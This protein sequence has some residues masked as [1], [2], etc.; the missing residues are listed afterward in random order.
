MCLAQPARILAIEDGQAIVELDGRRRRASMLRASAV[1]VGD[2]ALVAAGSVLRR[3]EP[4]E[5]ADLAELL[6]P[7]L[8]RPAL[9][10]AAAF[11]TPVTPDR[12]QG[13]PT[14]EPR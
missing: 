6:R 1:E 8:L 9:L 5:A 12:S 10:G 14:G 4:E 11:E 2:W 3:M 7:A 13:Q